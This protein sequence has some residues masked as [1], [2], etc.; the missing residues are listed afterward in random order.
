[1][2]ARN[3][4]KPLLRRKSDLPHD[5]MTSKA[6]N[7]HKRAD[8]FVRPADVDPSSTAALTWEWT[9]TWTLNME[10]SFIYSRSIVKNR[11]EW[12]GTSR[13]VM[14]WG[15][16]TNS[17]NPDEALDVAVFFFF[18]LTWVRCNAERG[19][20]RWKNRLQLFFLRVV[21]QEASTCFTL[22]ATH[23]FFSCEFEFIIVCLFRN[24]R[25]ILFCPC[26]AV[27]KNWKIM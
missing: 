4:E 7:D 25:G 2:K 12:C 6:L 22:T 20:R 13:I 9:W 5:S 14:E 8:E 1:M 23:F 10:Q 15:R 19:M 16:V 24:F 26:D 11:C 18:A 17:S 21:D 3:K 27:R